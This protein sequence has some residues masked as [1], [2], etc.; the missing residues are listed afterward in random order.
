[1]SLKSAPGANSIA[2]HSH[3]DLERIVGELKAS[4]AGARER[5]KSAGGEMPSREALVSILDGLFA[6]LF[7]THF[8]LSDLTDEGID[9]FVGHNLDATLR[10][11]VTTSAAG[12]AIQRAAV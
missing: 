2:R 3:W 9:Y 8:G 10:A 1:M 5:C 7:P 6:A 12:T 4:R 11:L